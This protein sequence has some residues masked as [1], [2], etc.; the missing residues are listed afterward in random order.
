[1][2]IKRYKEKPVVDESNAYDDI[3]GDVIFYRKNGTYYDSYIDGSVEIPAIQTSDKSWLMA[4]G[5]SYF[6]SKRKGKYIQKTNRL[7]IYGDLIP[8]GRDVGDFGIRK[9]G[10]LMYKLFIDESY[11]NKHIMYKDKDNHNVDVN[12]LIPI[13]SS[14]P[15]PK[16]FA[17]DYID[18]LL[19]ESGVEYD[20]EY[21]FSDLR[22]VGGGRLR[23]D[24]AIFNDGE[25]VKLIEHDNYEHRVQEGHPHYNRKKLE[26]DRRKN[27]YAKKNNIPLLRIEKPYRDITIQELIST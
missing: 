7:D 12:N 22:G 1:M 16:S 3:N 17:E 14:N 26:H 15:K 9:L 27:E 4:D 24:F 2:N 20:T 10:V 21:S 6:Y 25:L 8:S 23:Y 19:K 11:N 5:T 13:T 18:N